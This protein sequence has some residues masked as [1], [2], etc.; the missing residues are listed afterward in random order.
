MRLPAVIAAATT[1]SGCLYLPERSV[2]N[3]G[4]EPLAVER[5]SVEDG[6]I[7][8]PVDMNVEVT[9]NQPLDPES[10]GDASWSLTSGELSWT[11]DVRYDALT[12]TLSIDPR[13]SLRP[14]LWYTFGMDAFPLSI[15]GTAYEGEPVEVRF[16]T[17]TGTSPPPPTTTV[18]FADDVWPLLRGC[19]CHDEESRFMDYVILYDDPATFVERSV[20][21]PSREW[22]SWLVVDPGHHES[23]YLVYKLLGDERLGLPTIMGDAMPPG[24]PMPIEDIETVR[25]WIEQG[26]GP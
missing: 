20:A 23:S 19:A 5:L 10:L 1:L 8:L 7:D 9:F 26:A 15:M 6:A 2:E 11:A 3:R 4:R 17:G 22:R 14:D 16:R 25:D 12:R 21:T 18:S 24:A 13:A